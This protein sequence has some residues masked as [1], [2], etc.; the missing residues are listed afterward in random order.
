MSELK[1]GRRRTRKETT[2]HAQLGSAEHEAHSGASRQLRVSVLLSSR[3]AR[4]GVATLL[5][6]AA[7]LST[8]DRILQPLGPGTASAADTVIV[9]YVGLNSVHLL[10]DYTAG[11]EWGYACDIRLMVNSQADP[12]ATKSNGWSPPQPFLHTAANG[13]YRYRFE[14]VNTLAGFTTIITPVL[15]RTG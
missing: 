1:F 9:S 12:L 8:F 11:C 7:Y 15:G 2:R 3:L 14:S 6:F 10:L 5:F 4:V 13:T